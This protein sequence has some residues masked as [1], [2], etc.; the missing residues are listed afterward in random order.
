MLV[1]IAMAFFKKNW[2][3][4]FIGHGTW[5][6]STINIRITS[7]GTRKSQESTY[8]L[9]IEKKSLRFLSQ[10][11]VNALKFFIILSLWIYE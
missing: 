6:Y 3:Y 4:N 2:K 10:W 5:I 11:L 7:T 9:K 8:N 1:V